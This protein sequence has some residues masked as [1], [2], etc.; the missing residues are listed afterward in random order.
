MEKKLS[1]RIFDFCSEKTEHIV[2][3]DGLEEAFVGCVRRNKIS[4]ACYDYEKAMSVLTDEGLTEEQANETLNTYCTL[5][6]DLSEKFSIEKYSFDPAGPHW[7]RDPDL[8]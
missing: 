7:G 4:A 1:E 8:H 3:I 2:L 6:P 5:H